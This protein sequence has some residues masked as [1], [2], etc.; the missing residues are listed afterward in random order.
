MN[1]EV[2]LQSPDSEPLNCCRI[3]EGVS[4]GI[5]ARGECTRG[6]QGHCEDRRAGT[7]RVCPGCVGCICLYADVGEGTAE[8]RWVLKQHLFPQ[9]FC[10]G[11][12]VTDQEQ[13]P[14]SRLC[15]CVCVCVCVCVVSRHASWIGAARHP[16]SPGTQGGLVSSHSWR[17]S[18]YWSWPGCPLPSLDLPR[19]WT[20]G[21]PATQPSLV[22]P[23]MGTTGSPGEGDVPGWG[24]ERPGPVPQTASGK[25]GMGP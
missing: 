4:I 11:S 18:C 3:E 21:R 6:I 13:G 15:A 24:S 19:G 23:A 14:E 9:V 17:P 10:W 25:T 1:S 16:N 2:W 22:K 20:H 12:H 7:A 5:W 8:S